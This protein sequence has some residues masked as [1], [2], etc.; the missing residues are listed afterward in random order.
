MFLFSGAA[1]ANVEKHP[2]ATSL[3]LL[4]FVPARIDDCFLPCP[5]L[6]YAGFVNVTA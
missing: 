2:F 1:A 4:W 3:G 5:N 6:S